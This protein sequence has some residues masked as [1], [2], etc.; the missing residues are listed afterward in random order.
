MGKPRIQWKPGAFKAIR[1]LPAVAAELDQR[2]S[3]IASTADGLSGGTHVVHSTTS[4]G[5]GRHR[6]V[7]VAADREAQR[8][9]QKHDTLRRALDAGR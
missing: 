5:R 8:S 4:G 2:G 6:T 3:A 7:V 1:T 9:S